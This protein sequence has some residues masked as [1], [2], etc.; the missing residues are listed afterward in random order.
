MGL[1]R[2]HPAVARAA[3]LRRP[4]AS[5]VLAA[6]LDD[7][8]GSMFDFGLGLGGAESRAAVLSPGESKS[9]EGSGDGRYELCPGECGFDQEQGRAANFRFGSGGR[10]AHSPMGPVLLVSGPPAPASNGGSV[11]HTLRWRVRVSGNS[12]WSLGVV[13]AT[14][15]PH[16]AKAGPRAAAAAAAAAAVESGGAPADSW[17]AYPSYLAEQGRAGI[18]TTN[19]RLLRLAGLD[20]KTVDVIAD[21]RRRVLTFSVHSHA[22]YSVAVPIYE[23][24]PV[25]LA[26]SGYNG[27]VFTLLPFPDDEIALASVERAVQVT[28]VSCPANGSTVGLF[29]KTIHLVTAPPKSVRCTTAQLPDLCQRVCA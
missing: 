19:D 5:A 13:S 23:P 14:P 25:R 11:G 7:D 4:S 1:P 2:S 24:L 10:A 29:N 9:G 21:T 26:C 22:P 16:A 18:T 28:K 3:G 27:T 6:G 20:G 8:E 17:A 15:P 12:S